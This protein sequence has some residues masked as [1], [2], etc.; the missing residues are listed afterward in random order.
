[1]AERCGDLFHLYCLIDVDRPFEMAVTPL[2]ADVAR[3]PLVFFGLL[4]LSGYNKLVAVA[5]DRQVIFVHT[6][7][8]DL[9]EEIVLGLE[10]IDAGKPLAQAEFGSGPFEVS[11]LLEELVDFLL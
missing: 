7:G 10:N 3:D 9:D 8:F 11:Q 5:H 1:M 4:L 2:D 6:W